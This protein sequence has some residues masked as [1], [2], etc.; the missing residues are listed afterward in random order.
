MTPRQLECLEYVREYIADH[1]YAPSIREIAN[2]LNLVS[3]AGVLRLIDGLVEQGQLIK[4][5]QRNRGLSLPVGHDSHSA[6]L[7]RIPSAVLIAEL[8]RR[9]DL[10]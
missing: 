1:G 2:R 10:P 7:L 6:S 8:T 9:G 4:R 5:P 3:R